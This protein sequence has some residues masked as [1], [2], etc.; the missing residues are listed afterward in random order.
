MMQQSTRIPTRG[1][2]NVKEDVKEGETNG[3]MR[4]VKMS[5]MSGIGGNMTAREPCVL[6]S[7]QKHLDEP[8]PGYYR[9]RRMLEVLGRHNL[10]NISDLILCLYSH[11]ISRN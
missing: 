3:Q 2:G 5:E 7:S 6:H 10:D 1:S 9:G 8:T 4:R 11:T